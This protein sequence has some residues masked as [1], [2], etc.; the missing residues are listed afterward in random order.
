MQ[1]SQPKHNRVSCFL[2][3]DAWA[4]LF[5][6]RRLSPSRETLE[7]AAVSTFLHSPRQR[8]DLPH[9]HG[10]EG[11]ILAVPPAVANI[12]HTNGSILFSRRDNSA[13]AVERSEASTG[14]S[15]GSLSRPLPDGVTA[16]QPRHA[17][18]FAV[19]PSAVCYQKGQT[20]D[21]TAAGT[22]V[23]SGS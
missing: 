22:V 16:N 1:P 10:G 18:W 5:A 20:T 2:E 14:R 6:D 12:L 8:R 17:E 23:D 13:V 4:F 7:C 15:G 21:E 11:R 9:G 3:L 19:Q